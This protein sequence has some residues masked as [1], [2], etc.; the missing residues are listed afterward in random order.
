VKDA[1]LNHSEPQEN[2]VICNNDASDH[3]IEVTDRL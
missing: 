2:S 1:S 3:S